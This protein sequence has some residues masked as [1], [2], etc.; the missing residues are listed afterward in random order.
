MKDTKVNKLEYLNSAFKGLSPEKKEHV[1]DVARS[2]LEVQDNN[3]CLENNKI[4]PQGKKK[5]NEEN[6]GN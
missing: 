5:V 2:L 6:Y 1:L 3:S 4:I